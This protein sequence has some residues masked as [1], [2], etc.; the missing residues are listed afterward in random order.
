MSPPT[1]EPV[2]ATPRPNGKG[3]PHHDPE[4]ERA[5]DE[6]QV[7]V[8]EQVLG[9]ARGVG[10]V[11][12]AQHPAHMRVPESA[13][14]AAPSR[15]IVRVGA[16]RVAGLVGEA[17]VLAVGGHPF[18]QWPLDG[19]RAKHREQRPHRARGLEAA[20]SKQSV[21]ADGDAQPGEGVEDREHDQVWPVEELRPTPAIRPARARQAARGRQRPHDSI[22]RLVLDRDHL[23]HSWSVRAHRLV[24]HVSVGGCVG[25]GLCPRA[26]HGRCRCD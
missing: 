26:R 25:Q 12:A 21:I 23:G 22:G 15:C 14:R 11:L 4:R 10:H 19:H 18:G 6:A 2:S 17:V 8:G 1:T 5:A 24:L 16:V 20:V 9:V 3:E 7:R 13:D